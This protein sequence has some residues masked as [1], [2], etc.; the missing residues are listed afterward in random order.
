MG[1]Y[2]QFNVNTQALLQYDLG[3]LKRRVGCPKKTSTRFKNLCLGLLLDTN[4]LLHEPL[5]FYP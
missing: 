3:L 4:I 1:F 5:A 2:V